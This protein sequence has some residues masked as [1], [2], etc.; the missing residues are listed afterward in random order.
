MGVR[1]SFTALLVALLFNLVPLF[2]QAAE[3]LTGGPMA[4]Y[5]AMRAATV[6]LQ[7]SGAAVA[8]IEYW[9][10]GK[11]QEARMSVPQALTAA[12]DFTARIHI[13]GLEPGTVYEYRVRLDGVVQQTVVE[14]LRLRTEPLWQWRTDPPPYTVALGSCAYINEAPYDR[15][16]EP[17]GG[18]HEIF[19]TIAASQ[20]DLMLWLGDNIY[21]READYDSAW[22]MNYRY[23]R[24]RSFAPLQRLLQSTHH[25]ATWDDHDYGPDNSNSS[26]PLKATALELF[27][28]YWANPAYG[29][30]NT[31]GVFTWVSHHDADFFLLDDRYYRNSDLDANDADKRMLGEVQLRWLKDALLASRASFK[32]I[33]NGSQMLIGQKNTE[34]WTNFPAE[35]NDFLDWLAGANVKGVVLLSGDRHLTKFMRMERSGDYPLHELTCSPLTSGVRDPARDDRSPLVVPGTEVGERNYCT[36]TV[37][38][39]KKNRTLRIGVYSTQGKLLWERE[40]KQRELQSPARGAGDN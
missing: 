21:L 36:L 14:P 27:K 40:L 11:P 30:P 24:V 7:A 26:F 39:A 38:G 6:W 2:A 19:D 8:G 25:I 15:P 20:P 29:L 12:E 13:D 32:F 1:K 18:G 10:A 34:S 22:G 3:R 37:S 28:R 31:P 33:V 5:P 23:R 16:G 9:P 17:Y 35:R 4:G